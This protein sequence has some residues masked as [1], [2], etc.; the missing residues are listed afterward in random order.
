MTFH[1]EN[2]QLHGS[3]VYNIGGD[4]RLTEQSSPQE[5]AAVLQELRARLAALETLPEADRRDI[6][7]DLAAADSDADG[8]ETDTAQGDVVAG[9]LSRIAN[10]LRALG[11]TATAA[12]ELGAA[13]D[14][15]AQF[16]GQHL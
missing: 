15:L 9:R 6:D 2:W 14:T 16:A 3:K 11:G 1:Q 7:E 4:L 8:D 10:R 5:F 12:V 13:V